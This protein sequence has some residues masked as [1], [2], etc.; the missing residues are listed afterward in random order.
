MRKI[1]IIEDDEDLREGLAFSLQM[2]GYEIRCAGTKREGLERIRGE[3]FDLVLLDCNLPDGS[4]FDLCTQIGAGETIPVFMLTARNTEMDEVKALEL[5]VADFMSKPFSLAV[6]K[7]RIRKILNS[8]APD[9]RLVSGGITVD[10][11]GCRVYRRDEEIILS[12]VE[13]QLLLYLMENRNR[14]LSKEQIL[15]H[16]WDSQGK[17]VDENTLSVN[18]RR[19]RAKIEEDPGHPARIRTVHGIGYVWKEGDQ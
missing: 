18:I 5:G 16:V 15:E 4:G 11:D 12:R 10:R 7:A 6:L 2:D 14:V 8:S 1:L 9:M 17:F 19:L 3:S 13:Y